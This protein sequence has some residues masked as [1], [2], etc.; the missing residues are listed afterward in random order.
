[1]ARRSDEALAPK[2]GHTL[3]VLIACRISGCTKQKELSNED[4]ADNV[5]EAVRDLYDG[6]VV[7][8]VI[9]TKAK[10]ERL[11]RPELESVEA[12]YRSRKYDL[13]VF[14]DLSRLIRGGEA[15]RLLGVGV[16]NGTRTLCLNDGIDTVDPTWE[17]DALNACSEN[18]AHNERT[19]RRIK[20]KTMNRFRKS[21]HTAAR[22]IAG[23]IVPSDA[24][25][26]DDGRKDESATA[27][28]N[29]GARS[30]RMSLNCSGVADWFTAIGFRVGPYCRRKTWNGAMVRRL[31]GYPLLKGKPWRGSKHTVK[32]H[33]TG[34]RVSR[35]NPKGPTFYEAPHLAHLGEIEFDS[36]NALLDE[37]NSC[38]RRPA[39]SGCDP[40]LNVSRKRSRCPGKIARCWYCGADYVWGANGISGHLMCNGSREWNCWN[41]VGFAGAL[42]ATK[43]VA[44]ISARLYG[45]EAFEQQFTAMRA[46][47]QRNG[48]DSLPARWADLMM[49][50][51]L[52]E[53]AK[54]NIQESI[55]AA[56]P[57]ALLKQQLDEIDR[58]EQKLLFEKHDREMRE[59]QRLEL[60]ESSSMLRERMQREFARLAVNSYEFADLIRPLVAGF[61]VYVVRLCDGG[62][63]FSR[64]KVRLNLAGH[65]PD[66]NL[67][68]ELHRLVAQEITLDLWDVA[69][70]REQIRLEVVRLAANGL[71]QRQIAAQL[72]PKVTQTAVGN[73]VALHQRMLAL[74]LTDPWITVMEPQGTICSGGIA[75]GPNCSNSI[76]LGVYSP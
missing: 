53:K 19:S 31:Y 1:M 25:S 20:Q 72:S 38:H 36:L 34:R 61:H 55:R 56:G 58:E 10:G 73:A 45:L 69:P 60:P 74:G 49:R 46:E 59:Q 24:T 8:K 50:C 39:V 57:H 42:A 18:V 23:Y 32:D 22:P 71:T 29:E 70:Q 30:L 4:Q 27:I 48:K 65:F 37:A 2:N 62:H 12:A 17:E 33:G 47:A 21:G 6:S 3:V 52:H 43:L 51:A 26:Y 13:V 15:A 11:D 63:P 14:D 64:A 5:K 76:W 54:A 35:K 7:F 41:S 40:L 75:N 16:D 44:E 9:S 28:L 67:A 68:P 66:I